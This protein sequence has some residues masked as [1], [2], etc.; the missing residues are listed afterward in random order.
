MTSLA[1]HASTAQPL[2]PAAPCARTTRQ[3]RIEKARAER[4][5]QLETAKANVARLKAEW[6]EQEVARRAAMTDKQRERSYASRAATARARARKYGCDGDHTGDDIKALLETQQGLCAACEEDMRDVYHVDHIE[7][8]AAGGS[9][10]PENLQM[11]CIPCN[12]KKGGKHRAT[13]VY[14][15]AA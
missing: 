4:K 7:E 2:P 15:S 8:L 12:L 9:N 10:G 1:A 14:R 11:L 3:R 6:L 13:P 5:R